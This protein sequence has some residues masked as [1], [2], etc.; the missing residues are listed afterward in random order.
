MP[1]SDRLMARS[2]GKAELCPE[3]AK[4]GMVSVRAKRCA[5]SGCD[6]RASYGE[7]GGKV[8]LCAQHAEKGMAEPIHQRR[9]RAEK[10]GAK[11]SWFEAACGSTACGTRAGEERRN[12]L[13]PP[14]QTGV[15]S[16]RATG[17]NKRARANAGAPM[18]PLPASAGEG[19]R[20]RNTTS[21]KWAGRCRGSVFAGAR[22]LGEDG[23]A[24]SGGV[25]QGGTLGGSRYVGSEPP[26]SLRVR[27]SF[28]GA[29]KN[30]AF[31]GSSLRRH[32]SRERVARLMVCTRRVVACRLGGGL[33]GAATGV[34]IGMVHEIGPSQPS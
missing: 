4:G 8:E 9:K 18:I 33:G 16:G 2:G 29:W 26:E 3:H 5:H 25:V 11:T 19:D 21:A 30:G 20:R 28:V 24:A 32:I 12:G 27:M 22:R 14:A 6:Q 13:P 17:T 7:I 10:G 34:F 31:N 15:S 23:S 1:T